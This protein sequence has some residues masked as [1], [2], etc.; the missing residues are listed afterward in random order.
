MDITNNLDLHRIVFVQ[1]GLSTLA[2]VSVSPA[3]NLPIHLYGLFNMDSQQHQD[4]DHHLNSS[5]PLDGLRQYSILVVLSSILD[6]IWMYN[7]TSS[8]TSIPLILI[9]IGLIIKPISVITCLNQLN[10][11]GQG[12]G[13]LGSQFNGTRPSSSFQSVGQTVGGGGGR[14]ENTAWTAPHSTTSPFRRADQAAAPPPGPSSVSHQATANLVN[15][16]TLDLDDHDADAQNLSD[17]EVRK[18]KL[19]LDNRIAQKKLQIQQQQSQQQ[20]HQQ[21][22]S[23]TPTQQVD[24]SGYHTLE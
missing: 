11:S 22:L 3:Y 23:T 15:E 20:Q 14:R 9:L 7:W 5:G 18:A 21:G 19:E 16:F 6:L 10:R 13:T 17:D 8:T 1:V 2:S 4:H 12:F 24:K